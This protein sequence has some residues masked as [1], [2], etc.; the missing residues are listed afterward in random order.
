VTNNGEDLGTI[1][2]NVPQKTAQQFYYNLTDVGPNP[3][4]YHQL[5]EMSSTPPLQNP[6]NTLKKYKH[7]S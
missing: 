3:A 7:L 5:A 2:F 6:H 4:L 1:N